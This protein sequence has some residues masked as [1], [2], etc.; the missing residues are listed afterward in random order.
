[1]ESRAPR[2][3]LLFSLWQVICAHLPITACLRY[4]DAV[5]IDAGPDS[6]ATVSDLDVKYSS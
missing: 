3:F 4:S 2:R 1:M 5:R 6:G